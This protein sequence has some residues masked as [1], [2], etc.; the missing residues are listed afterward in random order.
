MKARGV[1]SV[2][3]LLAALLPGS[4]PAQEGHPLEGTWQGLWGITPEQR[5]FLTLILS[6]DGENI[7][8]EVNP[9]PAPGAIR[10]VR[11]DSATWSVYLDLD[12]A[13][14]RSGETSRVRA[15]ARLYDLGAPDRQMRGALQDAPTGYFRISR[16]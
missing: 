14:R 10:E 16:Q 5:N 15:Q 12:V 3:A 6:W 1:L 4:V 11:L 2:L 9:G 8:G 7:V 13:D